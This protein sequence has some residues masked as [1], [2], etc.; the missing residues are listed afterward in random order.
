MAL[1]SIDVSQ[2]EDSAIALKPLHPTMALPPIDVSQ[3]E[4]SAIALKPLHP[5]MALPPIDFSHFEDSALAA[6]LYYRL[7][8]NSIRRHMTESE[9]ASGSNS[10]LISVRIGSFQLDSE[11]SYQALPDD[12][13]ISSNLTIHGIV[14]VMQQYYY[15]SPWMALYALWQA[16]IMAEVA[17]F[18]EWNTKDPGLFK[19]HHCREKNH[20][21]AGCSGNPDS[22]S[23]DRSHSVR[24]ET[25]EADPDQT[26]DPR[27]HSTLLPGTGVYQTVI[28]IEM[29]QK[30][31]EVLSKLSWNRLNDTEDLFPESP[32]PI[33]VQHLADTSST[34]S[35]LDSRLGDDNSDG[36]NQ[37]DDPTDTTTNQHRFLSQ[38]KTPR[39]E[40]R[41]DIHGTA[42]E[43]RRLLREKRR[44]EREKR[45][46]DKILNEKLANP[47]THWP[48]ILP[49][50]PQTPC[51]SPTF[52]FGNRSVRL[53]APPTLPRRSASY[54]HSVP[55]DPSPQPDTLHNGYSPFFG[56]NHQAAQYSME[57]PYERTDIYMEKPK[58][59]EDY[60][61]WGYE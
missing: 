46:F 40:Q 41:T 58:G 36:N 29:L 21:E 10:S 48:E 20:V 44:Q 42:G 55:P 17:D 47:K 14:K 30:Q 8:E 34:V 24:R 57:Y 50:E 38:R 4:D 25:Q 5:T 32:H 28:D 53:K 27:N 11:R 23:V 51:H 19:A 1:S 6:N 54:E 16:A 26:A 39:T 43:E 35:P 15:R 37:P 56:H 52:F 18:K 60:G 59:W 2:F 3:F 22:K 31:F 61:N 12:N 9:T 33:P 7:A 13:L 49:E 45:R